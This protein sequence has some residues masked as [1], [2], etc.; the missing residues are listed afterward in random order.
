MKV[1]GDLVGADATLATR[2]GVGGGLLTGRIEGQNCRGAEKYARLVGWLR[3]E[4]LRGGAHQP[5]L[6][7]YGNSRGDLRLLEAADHGVDAG[8]LGTAG[9]APPLP[10]GWPTWRRGHP[11]GPAWRAPAA[12]LRRQADGAVVAVAAVS[13]PPKTGDTWSVPLAQASMERSRDHAVCG[14]C[15]RRD[16]GRGGCGAGRRLGHHVAEAEVEVGDPARGQGDVGHRRRSRR[17]GHRHDRRWS[18]GR[19]AGPEQEHASPGSP[20]MAQAADEALVS[21]KVTSWVPAAPDDPVLAIDSSD[22]RQTV[23]AAVGRGG[24][25]WWRS[26]RSWWWLSTSWWWS[27]WWSTTGPR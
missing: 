6:W 14:G 12:P 7:A 23:V 27:R 16:L 25:S 20:R 8:H 26:K 1:I 15:G 24:R 13:V 3:S 19:P 21:E 2:L 11:V 9:P 18:G 17:P 5:V 22:A 4:G 10:H